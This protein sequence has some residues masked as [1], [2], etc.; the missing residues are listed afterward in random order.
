M[1]LTKERQR[2]RN[3]ARQL[4][5]CRKQHQIGS[6]FALARAIQTC[7]LYRVRHP[8]WV[9]KLIRKG[10]QEVLSDRI[11][12]WDDI[13]GKPKGPKRSIGAVALRRLEDL[14]IIKAVDA[15]EPGPGENMADKFA[16]VG[17]RLK[18]KEKSC[19]QRYY[20]AASSYF[21]NSC[22]WKK[23]RLPKKKKTMLPK[24]KRKQLRE[25]RQP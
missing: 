7:A 20:A 21:P 25:T 4:L 2:L 19:E 17:A 18:I 3:C 16:V 1:G 6:P 10:F 11:K 15:Y 8:R 24:K 13:L 9:A 12:S 22:R 23:N 5:E 14:K